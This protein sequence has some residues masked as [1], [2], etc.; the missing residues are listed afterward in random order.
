MGTYNLDWAVVYEKGGETKLYFVIETKASLFSEALR[1]SE[2]AKIKCG[3][4]HFEAMDSGVKYE[5]SNN[6]DNFL[7]LAEEYCNRFVQ[8]LNK[9]SSL[10]DRNILDHEFKAR[11]GKNLSKVLISEMID[12][13][14]E[15]AEA[16]Y[17]FIFSQ[18][19]RQLAACEICLA[20]NGRGIFRSLVSSNRM[21]DNDLDAIQQ[22]INRGLSAKDKFGSQHRGTGIRNTIKLLLNRELRGFFCLIS[23]AAGFYIDSNDRRKFLNLQNINWNG[24]IVNMGFHSCPK[25]FK[26]F[27]FSLIRYI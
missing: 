27:K 3:R 26:V 11:I 14:V 19:Y 4:R 1:E 8:Q 23:G 25:H 21:V 5:V 15:H 12:N 18:Y 7:D 10:L 20:D 16:D 9:Y 6:F 13:I 17:T 22:V 2:D 24:T